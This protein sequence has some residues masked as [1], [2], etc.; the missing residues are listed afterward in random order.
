VA[1]ARTLR[2]H[3]G[4]RIDGVTGPDEYSAV[5]DNNVYTNLMAQRNLR[6]AATSAERHPR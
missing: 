5:A 3:G 6:A 1:L 4:F 2:P